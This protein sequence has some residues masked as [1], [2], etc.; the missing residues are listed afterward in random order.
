MVTITDTVAPT[1]ICQNITVQLDAD[2]NAV[3]TSAQI[4]NNS[5]D[6]C[7]TPNNGLT[8]SI[9]Q[10]DFDCSNVGSNTVTLTVTDAFGNSS[11]CTATVT[12]VDDVDPVAICQN[13]TVQLDV[14][15]EVTI[16]AAQVNN[17]S[18]DNCG[19]DTITLNPSSFTCAGVGTNSVTLTVTD[20]NGNVATCTAIVTVLDTVPPVALCRDITIDLDGSG[21]ASIIPSQVD[22][23]S[24]DACG[25]AS[26]TVS[27]NTFDCLNVGANTVTLVVT[28]LNGNVDSCTSIVT[29][30]DATAPNAICQN[31]TVALDSNGVISITAAQIDNGSID[32]CGIDTMTLSVSS[33]NCGNVGENLVTLTVTDV[34]GNSDNC[35]STITVVDNIAPEFTL[36]PFDIVIQPDS[37]NC[38]PYASWN[39]PIATDNC[40]VTSLTSNFQSGNSFPVGTTTVTYTAIDAAGNT[41][42][43]SFTVTVLANPLL[44]AAVADTF[45]CGYNVSCSG[46]SNGS[47]TAIPAGGCMPYSYLWSNGQTSQTATGL[48]ATTYSVTVTDGLGNTAT[49]TITLT[50]PS[51]LVVDSITSPVNSGGWNINCANTNNGVINLAVSGGADCADYNYAWTG[52]NGYTSTDENLIFVFAGTYYVTITDI[53]GCNIQD[54]ITL[55]EPELL[56]VNLVDQQDVSCSGLSDGFATVLANGGANGYQYLWSNGETSATADSLDAGI[57]FVSVT[58]NNGCIATTNVIIGEPNPLIAYTTVTSDYNGSDVSCA[59]DADGIA[60][61][62]VNGGTPGYTYQWSNGSTDYFATDLAAGTYFV[63]STDANGCDTTVSVTL[64]DPLVLTADV[65]SIV[66]PS[67]NGIA[68]GSAIVQAAGGTPGYFYYWSNTQT[69]ATATGLAAGTYT[70][71]VSDTNG[72]NIVLTITI[73]EPDVLNPVLLDILDVTCNGGSNGAGFINVTGGT[74]PYT[75]LWSNGATTED[76]NGVGAGDYTVQ[77]TDANGCDTS[78]T[79]VISQP[80]PMVAF[81]ENQVNVY[82]AGN[83]TGEASV[84]ISGGVPGYTYL[85]DNGQTTQT[86]ADLSAGP[87]SI[88]IRDANNCITIV[89]FVITESI[90]LS[91]G[92]VDV[93]NVTCNGGNNGS[94]SFNMEGGSAPY[95][96]VWSNGQTT[97][98]AINLQAGDHSVTI[99]DSAGCV[100]QLSFTVSQP[101]ALTLNIINIVQPVCSGSS[102]GHA[103]VQVT[104]GTPNYQYA[105]DNG[106]TTA[107]ATGFTAGVHTV[108]VTDANGCVDSTTVTITEPASLSVSIIGSSNPTCFGGANGTATALVGGGVAPYDYS[109]S[110]SGGT[111]STATG[112]SAGTHIVIVTDANGCSASQTYTLTQPAQ[113]VVTIDGG[114]ST[115]CAGESVTLTASATGGTGS[116]NFAWNNGLGN[117][118]THTVSPTVTTTYVVIAA[119]A[120][121]CSATDSVTVSIYPS[122]AASFTPSGSSSCTFPVTVN[123]TNTSTNSVTY[124]WEFGNGDSAFTTNGQATYDTIGSYTVMLIA[125]STNGCTDTALYVYNVYPAP[126]ALFSL[127]GNSGCAPYTVSFTNNSVDGVTYYWSFGD[128]DTSMLSNPSHTYEIPGTYN[129]TLV[130]SGGGLCND[131]L[132][133]LSAVT[134]FQTPVADF[135]SDY[136][137]ITDPDGQIQFTNLSTG[138]TTYDWDFGDGNT[139]TLTDPINNYAENGEFDVTLIAYSGAGCSD[140]IIQTVE[141][142]LMKGL[143]MPNAMIAG[144]DGDFGLFLPK[145]AGIA[146]YQCMVFDKW[147]NLLWQSTELVNGQPSEGWDGRYNGVVVPLGAY[148]WKADATFLDGTT[149][150]GMEYENDRFSNTGNVTVLE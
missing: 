16:T 38:N 46:A 10:T 61:V 114:G 138:A 74:E 50:E 144:G 132:Q 59:G 56:E 125:T 133:L 39:T 3:I 89:N 109:W 26:I 44:I 75:Y 71:T 119:N 25:I 131:T 52:P 127:S 112:L 84:N 130:V 121:G 69:G 63:T 150:E 7:S 12:I 100:L 118:A 67:C 1:V 110:P 21:N 129:V 90:V 2:G 134:V 104:G 83:N 48:S 135:T 139:S 81:I 93:N 79:L 76:L 142:E 117:G 57:Y 35:F 15:G 5:T 148:I 49:T 17:G 91:A 36:C 80:T 20:L 101:D 145:G 108:V 126:T 19:I 113:V 70:V 149:W 6:N 105:W 32:A 146:T 106:Q 115:I 31:I 65:V 97:V 143:Y 107:T 51:P 78:F 42:T 92:D 68:N 87:H 62:L 99:T 128:G 82:C 123:F 77:I 18:F 136:F 8:Y 4:D 120:Q 73:N 37:S 14:N 137:N 54:S 102:T 13:I 55:T 47:A 40:A 29:V 30:V 96:Y 66:T 88:T 45:N 147:G 85:W 72:C 24:G 140:T 111:N 23:G 11:S 27:P 41:T 124:Y 60:E 116:Y 64:I 28:D 9:S 53:N 86:V 95:S 103:T 22:N 33:F 94:I 58:D 43:C 34:N 141:V 122:P 98:P